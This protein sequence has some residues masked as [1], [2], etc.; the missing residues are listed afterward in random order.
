MSMEVFHRNMA[1][2]LYHADQ[3]PLMS[4]GETKV[5]SIG[6]GMSK[7]WVDITN[8]RVIPTI[9]VRARETK[10]VRPDILSADGNVEIV[11][12]GWVANKHRPGKTQLIDQKK[13]DRIIIRSGH[14]GKTTKTIEYLVR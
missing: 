2:T 13:L 10:A 6:G 14:P 3:L 1:F 4:M 7:V 9:T 12:A 11:S 8:E 5:E